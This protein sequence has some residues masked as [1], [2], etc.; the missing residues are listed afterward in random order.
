M[1]K[2]KKVLVNLYL[3]INL[4]FPIAWLLKLHKNLP[5]IKPFYQYLSIDHYHFYFDMFIMWSSYII[6]FINVILMI[7]II[8]IPSFKKYIVFKTDSGVL[9]IHT[10]SIKGTVTAISNNYKFLN[11]VNVKVRMTR[12]KLVIKI[13]GNYNPVIALP[14]EI[15][16]FEKNIHDDLNNYLHDNHKNMSIHVTLKHLSPNQ[17]PRN[18]KIV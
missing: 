14:I 6:I 16:E 5:I 4:F 12:N 2:Y 11:I 10:T 3:L 7:V 9:K 8:L 13:Y 17:K 15:E 1:K 18:S